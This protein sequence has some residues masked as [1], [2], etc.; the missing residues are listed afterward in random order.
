[1]SPTGFSPLLAGLASLAVAFV[2]VLLPWLDRV[3][4]GHT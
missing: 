1:M 3:I 4:A 2:G